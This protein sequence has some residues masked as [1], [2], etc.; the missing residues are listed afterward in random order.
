MPGAPWPV[1]GRQSHLL[2][3]HASQLADEAKRLLE[4]GNEKRKTI[5]FKIL[6]PFVTSVL[7]F[8]NKTRSQPSNSE[9]LMLMQKVATT[10]E[11]QREDT[12]LIKNAINNGATTPTGTTPT[13]LTWAQRAANDHP[14]SLN[15]HRDTTATVPSSKNH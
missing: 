6:E 8:V 9:V 13:R 5:P 7:D 11:A 10:V 3:E 4:T 15:S 1:L 2:H 12:I 14:P